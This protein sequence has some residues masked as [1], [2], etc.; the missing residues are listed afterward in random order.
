[1]SKFE[2]KTLLVV[3]AGP[4]EDGDAAKK[5]IY[6]V[7]DPPYRIIVYCKTDLS[8]LYLQ[9]GCSFLFAFLEVL[10]GAKKRCSHS[11][12][13]ITSRYCISDASR[14]ALGNLPT[15]GDF[16]YCHSLTDNVALLY[17]FTIFSKYDVPNIVLEHENGREAWSNFRNSE[18]PIFL[19]IFQ[20]SKSLVI[21]WKIR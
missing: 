7:L 6:A 10:C 12:G 18:N 2:W 16:A 14:W 13:F 19:Q 15:K 20:H 11:C 1:M 9:N 17:H 21:Q 5:M 8:R 3:T 4:C